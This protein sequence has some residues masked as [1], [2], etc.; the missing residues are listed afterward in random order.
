MTDDIAIW[1]SRFWFALPYFIAAWAIGPG[2]T[3]W[4]NKGE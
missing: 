3:L 2:L 4:I 1:L